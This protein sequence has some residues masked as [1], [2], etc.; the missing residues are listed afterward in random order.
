MN[1]YTVLGQCRC[2]LKTGNHK[3]FK[4][5]YSRNG[6]RMECRESFLTC[7]NVDLL[8]DKELTEKQNLICI[9]CLQALHDAC[10]FRSTVVQSDE[11][12]RRFISKREHDFGAEIKL[13]LHSE[14]DIKEE[15]EDL[16]V[17][18]QHCGMKC[19]GATEVAPVAAP[20]EIINKESNKLIQTSKTKEHSMTPVYN[21]PFQLKKV[22]PVATTLNIV[23]KESNKLIQTSKASEHPMTPVYNQPLLFKKVVI[24]PTS[25]VLGKDFIGPGT[26]CQVAPV[27]TPLEIVN[28]KSKILLQTSKANEHPKTPVSNQPF[29]LKKAFTAAPLK[30]LLHARVPNKQP[31]KPVPHQ[32]SPLKQGNATPTIVRS[33]C[34]F[35]DF[36]LKLSNITIKVLSDELLALYDARG[37]DCPE[38]NILANKNEKTEVK[39]RF[40]VALYEKYPWLTGSCQRNKMYCFTCLLFANNL[41]SG[42]WDKEGYSD[43]RNVHVAAQKHSQNVRHLKNVLLL[44][45]LRK[46]QE[47]PS[48][49]CVDKNSIVKRNRDLM[50]RLIDT[51]ILLAKQGLFVRGHK[52]ACPD[53]NYVETLS[54]LREYDALLDL[55]LEQCL[56]MDNSQFS[57]LSAETQNDLIACIASALKDAIKEEIRQAEFVSAIIEKGSVGKEMSLFLRYVSENGVEE[58]FLGFLDAKDK[59]SVLLAEQLLNVLRQY[60]CTKKLV[61]LS[62]PFISEENTKAQDRL[63]KECPTAVSVPCHSHSISLLL[64]N[65]LE[66]VQQYKSFFADVNSI[67]RFFDRF[68]NGSKLL[69]EI[70]DQRIPE[71]TFLLHWYKDSRAVETILNCSQ[72]VTSHDPDRAKH[73]RVQAKTT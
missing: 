39:R 15:N 55:H 52:K 57:G 4:D 44:T 69:K 38:L 5:P 48:N 9:S 68:P 65:S 27:A 60:E 10:K 46:P 45:R 62:Y 43:L 34:C 71:E 40:R 8:A 50:K 20:L 58:R 7:F 33:E 13:G 61:G 11:Y 22:A 1:E 59:S 26:A 2:C 16:V 49:I 66:N 51:V 23:N 28:N 32:P 53:S 3:N 25:T 41:T 70:V 42:K 30:K 64:T 12:L 18:N 73:A 36:L 47:I 72:S 35:T 6:V 19:G 54:Y 24:L 14:I 31:L 21:Q 63:L 56:A 37:R 17:D 67:Q 29:L